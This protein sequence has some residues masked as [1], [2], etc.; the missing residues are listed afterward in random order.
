[1]NK[2]L[3]I[4]ALSISISS[5]MTLDAVKTKNRENLNRISL[6]MTKTQV[7]D[8]MGTETITTN[9]NPSKVSNPWRTEILKGKDDTLYEIIFYYTDTKEADGAIKDNE[10]TPIVLEQNKVIG[11]GWS[12][13]NDNVKKY[14]IEV[15]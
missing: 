15:N 7:L 1:M 4:I 14:Q 10:L 8:I 13:L 9:G 12:F 5:C 3:F 2:I 6:G 11:W